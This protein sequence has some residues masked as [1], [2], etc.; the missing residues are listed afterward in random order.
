MNERGTN[1]EEMEI[2]VPARQN[3][4]VSPPL[5]P[6]PFPLAPS[7][8]P[9]ERER[10][11]KSRRKLGAGGPRGRAIVTW[12]RAAATSQLVN[13]ENWLRIHEWAGVNKVAAC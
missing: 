11:G 7:P 12:R 3:T 6:S 10:A 1:R 8:L 4:P 2:F 9:H 5:L 13:E